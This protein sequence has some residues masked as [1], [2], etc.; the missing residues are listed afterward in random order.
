MATTQHRQR[1]ASRLLSA[2]RNRR[3]AY[4][5]RSTV[6]LNFVLAALL[7]ATHF[8]RASP[9]ILTAW[10]LALALALLLRVALWWWDPDRRLRSG[11]VPWLTVYAA[12]TGLVALIWGSGAWLLFD[13]QSHE[14]QALLALAMVG[15]GTGALIQNM[16]SWP[17]V[18][19]YSSAL[20]IPLMIRF[21]QAETEVSNAIALMLG[22]FLV[23]VMGFSRRLSVMFDNQVRLQAEQAA[24]AEAEHE[25][26][27]QFKRLIESTRAVLW[28]ASPEDLKFVYIS[29]EVEGLLGYPAE[30]WLASPSFWVDHLHPEDAQWAF[31]YCTEKTRQLE[32][33]SFD[34]RMVSASGD[35]VWIRDVVNVVAEDGRAV[36]VGGVMIDITE[37]KQTTENLQYVH[38]LQA[39]MVEISRALIRQTDGDP[40]PLLDDILERTGRTCRVDRTYFMR[41]DDDLRHFTNTHEWTAEGIRPEI[42]NLVNVPSSSMPRLIGAIKAHEDVTLPDV[43]ALPE[44]W[45][46]ERALLQAQDIKS[47][48]VVPVFSE[49]QLIGM[50][51]FDSVRAA[52]G[53]ASEEIALLRVLGDLLGETMARARVNRNLRETEAQRQSAEALANM[54]VWRWNANDDTVELSDESADIL[55]VSKRHYQRSDTLRWVHP[56]DQEAV[57]GAF[58]RATRSGEALELECRLIQPR[59]RETVWLRVHAERSDDDNEAG[60]FKGYLQDISKRKRA[61]HELFRHAHYDRL[62]GLPNW[63]LLTERLARALDRLEARAGH[64]SVLVL[65]LDHFKKVNES[66]GHDIGDRV[67]ADA[68]R[69]LQALVSERDTVARSG[70]DEFLLLLDDYDDIGYPQRIADEIIDAFRAPFQIRGRSLVLTASVGLATAPKD[71]VTT[72]DLIRNADTAMY[73]SKSLG[74]DAMVAFDPSMIESVS[75]QLRLEEALRGA[76]DRGE[77][78]IH[79]QPVVRLCDRRMTGVEA[80]MRWQHPRL[81]V[82]SP[83]EFIPLAEQI[84]LIDELYDYLMA[85]LQIDLPRW[86]AHQGQQLSVSINV[87]PRQFRNPHFAQD[88]IAALVR[89]DLPPSAIRIEITEG[90]LLSG[91]DSVPSILAELLDQGVGISMDDF[92]TGYSSLSYLRDYP[93]TTVKIDQRFVRDVGHDPRSLQLVESILGMCD[94]LNIDV[95]A[96]GVETEAQAA[97]L[98]E[99]GCGYGQGFLFSRAV[100]ASV[101][102][103]WLSGGERPGPFIVVAPEVARPE[104]A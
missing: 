3:L 13:A 79:Y 60:L 15:L 75:R 16:P 8:D 104:E 82:V 77:I 90:V 42:Q 98:L 74:R 14:L 45:R 65:D 38:G 59:T 22:L 12:A 88:L 84:G 72:R 70:G 47:L 102:D 30:E 31:D 50:V 29:P 55:G 69:R 57:D 44:E 86:R 35:I 2:A 36:K 94:A 95:V 52:R 78:E 68:A 40:G 10:A 17:I 93:F 53:F 61:E 64:L 41:F 71:G 34:Y 43:D 6:A 11:R 37:L 58:R 20:L 91:M 1:D 19:F 23:A 80:L 32:E 25:Q 67:L 48:I 81:G 63:V 54:G 99:H 18:W 101:V 46:A 83:A 9:R 33:H 66:L 24:Q 26:R 96:E 51:G 49:Q 87:S 27:L 56:A 28:E 97:A 85:R 103:D 62:T 89:A 4:G 100:P 76:L 7:V 73:Q 39:L 92:G 21:Y 5:L